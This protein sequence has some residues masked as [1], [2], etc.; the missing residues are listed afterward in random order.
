[1]AKH[2][3]PL[4]DSKCS[5]AKPKDK[6]YS[7][8]DGNGLILFVRKTGTKVWRYKYKKA[9]GKDGLMTLSN[10]PS[11]TLKQA[12]DKRR[13]YE[14]LLAQDIDPIEYETTQKIKKSNA[15]SFESVARDWHKEYTNTGRWVEH[16]SIKALR[17]LETYVFPLIGDK[18]IDEVK[19]KDLVT[20]LRSIEEKGLTEVL[21]KSRQRF[22][23]IFAYAIS[24]GLIEDNPAYFLKDVFVLTKKTKHYPQLSL[25]KLPELLQRLK[26]DNGYLL[27]R[28]CTAF[29]LHVFA[30]SSEIRF[31]RWSEFNFKNAIWT[32]P[33]VRELVK[34]QRFSDRGAKMKTEHLI[35]LSPQV[36]SI[37]NEIKVYSGMTDNVFP[38][39]GDPQGFICD[40]V[41]NDTLR[42]I[43]YDTE[44]DIC[45]HGFRGMACSALV[46]STLFQKEAVEK[47]MSHQERDQVRLAYTHQAEYMEER[48]A[49]LNWWSDYLD[50]NQ[51][52]YIS[53][54]DFT[55][56]LLGEDLINFKYANL[57]N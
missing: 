21:K 23:A 39:N 2:I 37:L 57:K 30:R 20:V 48:K 8:Y 54:F 17:V 4:T 10:F 18:P 32:I 44:K 7:L 38:K 12:R 41:V 47:Q 25:E 36:L 16:T 5:S 26:A 15:F 33:A 22:N 13:E 40:K 9:N 29:T 51:E 53:P 3:T 43:G 11:L 6:D 31:A 42:R 14:K 52:S 24:R 28:L 35:P 50:A 34:G 45:G 55:R 1:M 56:K 19:S 49:M 46:Q 27:T